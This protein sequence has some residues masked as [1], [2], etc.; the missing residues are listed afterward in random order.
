MKSLDEEICL[1]LFFLLPSL[2][3]RERDSDKDPPSP[4]YLLKIEASMLEWSWPT[5]NKRNIDNIRSVSLFQPEITDNSVLPNS[6]PRVHRGRKWLR[7]DEAITGRPGGETDAAKTLP[8]D[9]QM[10]PGY[11]QRQFTIN[12]T[13]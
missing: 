2:L 11:K 12:K 4:P 9:L 1:P 7:P 8:T 13:D 5:Q 10:L 3:E 6:R